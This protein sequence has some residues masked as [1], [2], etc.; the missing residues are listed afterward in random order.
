[1]LED[2]FHLLSPSRSLISSYWR[3]LISAIKSSLKRRTKNAQH[4]DNFLSR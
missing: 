4:T 2:D 3:K 1:M